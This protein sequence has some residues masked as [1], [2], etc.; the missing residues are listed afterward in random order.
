MT[1]LLSF[2]ASH[3]NVFIVF[4]VFLLSHGGNMLLSWFK[5]EISTSNE[6]QAIQN[7]T[8]APSAISQIF[9]TGFIFLH[10]TQA[11]T[12]TKSDMKKGH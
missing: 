7:V 12:Q 11:K 10:C 1:S 6:R 9:L 2:C 3:L 4:S 8:P 5:M